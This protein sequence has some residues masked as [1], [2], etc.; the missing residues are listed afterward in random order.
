[1]ALNANSCYL[2]VITLIYGFVI[3]KNYANCVLR[4]LQH[5]AIATM[6]YYFHS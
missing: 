2:S 1:M 6:V 3:Y 5:S 4:E